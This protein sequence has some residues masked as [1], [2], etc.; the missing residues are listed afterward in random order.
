VRV[1]IAGIWILLTASAFAVEWK[2]ADD[3]VA[4]TRNV[5]VE[6]KDGLFTFSCNQNG[7]TKVAEYFLDVYKSGQ[8]ADNTTV[9][10]SI[11]GK[12]KSSQFE[13]LSRDS[14]GVLL[15]LTASTNEQASNDIADI[16]DRIQRSKSGVMLI[17]TSLTKRAI[18][19]SLE[20]AKAK[21]E[22][23]LKLC[24]Q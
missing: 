24:P 18:N 8:C 10:L 14:G 11:D 20:G 2:D 5:V 9:T 23:I 22:R 15:L 12:K 21:L 16:T 19:F 3:A 13:C 1:L 7:S 17:T 6:S 4:K